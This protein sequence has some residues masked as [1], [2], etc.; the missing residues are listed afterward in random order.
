VG[1]GEST[2]CICGAE[3]RNADAVKNNHESHLAWALID[4]AK[5]HM[6]VGECNFAVVTV[7]AGDS[8]VAIRQLLNL[9]AAQHIPLEPRLVQLCKSW[10]DAYVFHEEY[11]HLRRVIEGFLMPQT[12]RTSAAIRGG[13][14]SSRYWT[15]SR[16]GG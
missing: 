5:P 12:I 14:T 2:A 7:G 10:L 6:N 13:A 8:F 11:A 3:M 15:P 4:A 16:P 9:V 1:V